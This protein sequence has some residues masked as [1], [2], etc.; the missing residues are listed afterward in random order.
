[1]SRVPLLLVPGL[2]CDHAVWDPVIPALSHCAN[3]SV[4][5]HGTEDSVTRM[6]ERLLATAPAQFAIAGHSMGGR[7]A[8]E[9][10]RL[11]PQRVLRL[12]LLDTGY[13]ARTAG[14]AGE[15]EAR[16]RY[17]L[18]EV[19]QT[20]G[21]RAMA[22]A[23]VQGMVSPARLA[24]AQLIGDIVAMFERKSAAIFA[25]QI[26]ALLNRPDASPVL[27]DIQAPTLVLCGAEDSWAPVA[28]HQGIMDLIP[29]GH[30]R[31]SVVAGAGHMSPMEKPHAVAE[32]L[33]TWLTAPSP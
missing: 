17:A 24:D 8:L 23:W 12:A 25:L 21:V 19:A 15:E 4:V 31:L 3:P 32:A 2:M 28:Q 6:A 11:A 16:K 29:A 14:P 5:D 13:Q 33:C 20:Q 22:Q 18:L 30:A 27:Q 26:R 10:V 9:V 1:M 7:V